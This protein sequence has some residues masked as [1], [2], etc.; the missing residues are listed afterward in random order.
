MTAKPKTPKIPETPEAEDEFS[1]ATEVLKIF[2]DGKT[3]PW[4]RVSKKYPSLAL[5]GRRWA[6]TAGNI[7]AEAAVFDWA[8]ENVAG[9]RTRQSVAAQ[10][11]QASE[12]TAQSFLADL[13]DLHDINM[14]LQQT[15]TGCR[16]QQNT[17]Q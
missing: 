8:M 7:S 2:S 5:R 6:R 10:A 13:K 17:D 1:T 11:L 9:D 12:Q 3:H 4:R 15:E 16:K 14:L